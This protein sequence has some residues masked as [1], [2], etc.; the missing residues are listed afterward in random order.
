MRKLPKVVLV[1]LV[2]VVLVV[3][4]LTV[5]WLNQA[6][7][8]RPGVFKGEPSSALY[9]PIATRAADPAPLK[10]DELFA[11]PTVDGLTRQA[12][13]EFADCGEVLDGVE[14]PGCTQALRAVYGNGSVAGQFVVF[15]LADSAAADAFVT[16]LGQGGFVRQAATFDAGRSRAQARALGHFVT[17][18]WV[19]PAAGDPDL[20][21]A[22][23]ALDGLGKGLQARVLAAS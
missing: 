20:G 16:A 9:A 10:L 5:W 2:A 4:G 23:V 12:T 7:S 15:N 11:Q 19:G 1:P 13:A 21:P 17:V 8:P 22:H 14:A 3:A 6:V 18:S